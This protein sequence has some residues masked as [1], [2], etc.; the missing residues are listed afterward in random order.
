MIFQVEIGLFFQRVFKNTTVQLQTK[1]KQHGAAFPIDL[2]K[3]YIKIY[4]KPND[5]VLDPFSEMGTT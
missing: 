1:G 2:A 5:L 3:H 4:S